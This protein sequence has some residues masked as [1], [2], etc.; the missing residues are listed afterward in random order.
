MTNPKRGEV[1]VKLGE[2]EWNGR[3]T[4]DALARIETACNAGIVKVLGNLTQGDLRTTDLGNILLPIIRGGGND[5][6]M[7]E[8]N[9]AIWDAG[10]PATMRIC[11]EILA[12]ALTGG[13]ASGNEETAAA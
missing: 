7:K 11:G 12:K 2:K 13:R 4:L 5:V 1:L 8:V 10:I 3:V 6:T 9:E